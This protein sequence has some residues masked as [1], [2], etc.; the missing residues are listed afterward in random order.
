MDPEPGK[1]EGRRI[2]ATSRASSRP[3]VVRRRSNFDSVPGAPWAAARDKLGQARWMRRNPTPSEARLWEFLRRR[4]AA[5][6]KFRR[7]HVV[8]GYIVDFYCPELRLVIEV[9]GPIHAE[10]I[11][12]DAARERNLARLGIDILR[13]AASQVID[14]PHAV[15]QRIAA[16]CLRR[17]SCVVV[18]CIDVVRVHDG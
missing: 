1:P 14:D 13:F 2:R 4:Q 10:Q 15:R 8:A 16:E 3:S 6:F 7:Q 17:A 5:G 18:R 12:E 9:D 11:V